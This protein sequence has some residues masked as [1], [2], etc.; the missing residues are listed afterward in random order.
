MWKVKLAALGAAL[1]SLLAFFVR[2]RV[3]KNQRDHAVVVAHTIRVRHKVA[4]QRIVVE[5]ERAAQQV[6]RSRELAAE[7]EKKKEEREMSQLTNPND[8]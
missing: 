8:F 6:S 4:K 2:F 3:V 1:L 5:K 7:L